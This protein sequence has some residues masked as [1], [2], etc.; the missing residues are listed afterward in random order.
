MNE[1]KD[2]KEEGTENS[3]L[4][5]PESN[6]NQELDSDEKEV[7][8][9]PAKE[10]LTEAETQV[11]QNEEELVEEKVPTEITS[12]LKETVNN[13]K[14]LE[15]EKEVAEEQEIQVT[16]DTP[17]DKADTTQDAVVET[18]PVV[19]DIEKV[20]T[21][22]AEDTSENITEEVLTESA[23]EQTDSISTNE[24]EEEVQE[25]QIIAE[26]VIANED[27]TQDAA[28]TTIETDDK[29]E[30][31]DTQ[32]A[33]GTSENIT[34]EVLTESTLEQTESTPTNET[35][36]ESIEETEE[37]LHDEEEIE[38]LDFD[39]LSI[40]KILEI[41]KEQ[42]SDDNINKA[43]KTMR[44]L[45]DVVNVHRNEARK[46]ALEAYKS[47]NNDSEEGFA[48]K[49]DQA[50]IEFSELFKKHVD[51]RKDIYQSLRKERSDNLSAKKAIIQEIK[52]ISSHEDQKGSLAKIKKLQ[53]Q[54]KE[55][56]S[57]P[58][59]DAED[60]Y[61]TYNALLDIF[62]DH[63]SI[64]Y[65]LK[66]IDRKKNL[67]AKLQLCEKAEDLVNNEN[68]NE[69]LKLLKHLHEEYKVIG[70]VPKEKSDETWE[71][72]KK[73]SDALY[74]KK[75]EYAEVY[76]K[77]LNENME[78]K[79]ALCL[80]VEPFANFNSER[81][82]EWNDKTKELLAVQQKW[83]AIGS[84]PREVAKSINKQFWGNFKQFFNNKGK[85]FERLEAHRKENL[86]Q[87]EALCVKAEELKDS[88]NWNDTAEALK[89]LQR[90]WKE[91]GPV[92]ES[93]REKIYQRFKAACD[94]FFNRKRDQRSSRD[95][96]FK[97]NLKIKKDIC[98]QMEALANEGSDN[99]AKLNELVDAYLAAGYVPKRD[100][101]TILEKF[102]SA[103]EAF[104]DNYPEEDEDKKE[105]IKIQALVA[106]N[107]KAP[108]LGSKMRRQ[109]HAIR[110]KITA[111]ENDITLWE[112][113]LTFF[114][115]SK[116]ADKLKKEFSTKIDQANKKLNGLKAQLKILSK[117]T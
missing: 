79:Q 40:S 49:P 96:E 22:E 82:K 68:V 2:P 10:T 17:L 63:K 56:G 9:T 78:A 28:V 16:T 111:L 106:F 94:Y 73:A 7:E 37:A 8:E 24:T 32:E 95:K 50:F 98:T 53:Q 105:K 87:K 43:D 35:E 6:K 18:S 81:I 89:K 61:K 55:I 44:K 48:F 92:P 85:F 112:N 76:K 5:N 23:P 13:D 102:V 54:W 26:T 117:M 93:Q 4:A 104:Y 107:K 99:E 90:E 101:N 47:T 30:S 114:A 52:E 103:F 86:E 60:L 71:R 51:R 88:E 75:R 3:G 38:E 77:Q 21:Q 41:S 31:V 45:R 1:D 14:N 66:E 46:T 36:E 64:E 84:L 109:E 110:K 116:T 25:N 70:P 12:E 100:M 34:E 80:E 113:N 69:A 29:I 115:N 20:D 58:Q 108:Q 74:D 65:E 97:D 33:E 62:Y 91:I 11:P 15:E 67:E 27:S 83:E 19:E 39:S 57:V 59:I 72:F 42:L